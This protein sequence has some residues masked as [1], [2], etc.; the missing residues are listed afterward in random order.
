MNLPE[1]TRVPAAKK[2]FVADDGRNLV[3]TF[4]LVS[5]LFFALGLLE[6]KD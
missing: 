1:T 5:S 3:L 6:R 4:V 2:M